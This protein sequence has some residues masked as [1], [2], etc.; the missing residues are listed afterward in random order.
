MPLILMREA[1]S[2]VVPAG[3][4]EVIS[5]GI[6]AFKLNKMLVWYGGFA[7]HC[8]LYPTAAVLDAF[9]DEL[10]GYTTSKGTVQFP[11][12]RPMPM[13]LI[14]KLVRARVADLNR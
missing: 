10:R 9:K 3:A 7:G 14:K 8:S 13:V 2:S 1:I 12:A 6:P 4:V 5:Y 11:L